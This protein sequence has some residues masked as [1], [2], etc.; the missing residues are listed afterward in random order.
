MTAEQDVIKVKELFDKSSTIPLYQK[1]YSWDNE[2]VYSEDKNYLI[3]NLILHETKSCS[4]V[5]VVYG[6]QRVTTLALL[7]MSSAKRS[8]LCPIL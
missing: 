8:I 6:Q 3:S 7:L 5:S 1:L 2:Q 4:S